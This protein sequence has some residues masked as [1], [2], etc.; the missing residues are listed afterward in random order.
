[1]KVKAATALVLI[2]MGAGGSASAAPPDAIRVGGPSAPRDA[3]I[4]IVGTSGDVRG[5]AF[6]VLDRSGRVVLR[7][8]LTG[9]GGNAAPWRHAARADLSRVRAAGAYRVRFG[10]L[11]SRPW[12]VREDAVSAPIGAI[13]GYF[14]ANADGAEASPR[15]ARRTCAMR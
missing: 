15:T 2:S 1:M 6:S 11:T 9:A 13:L 14:A 12:S 5:R 3:K 8:R 10:E 7:G 4:A